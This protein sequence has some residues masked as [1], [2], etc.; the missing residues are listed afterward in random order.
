[1]TINNS[2]KHAVQVS[3]IR[4]ASGRHALHFL[5][6]FTASHTMDRPP[7]T[8][9]FRPPRLEKERITLPAP[10]PRKTARRRI[11]S[12]CCRQ[13]R[14]EWASTL[15]QQNETCTWRCTIRSSSPVCPSSTL[16]TASFA[17][18]MG[19]APLRNTRD[20]Y[21]GV[22]AR[23]RLLVAEHWHSPLECRV[24]VRQMRP[25]RLPNFSP[26]PASQLHQ[27]HTHDSRRSST[28]PAWEPAR[29]TRRRASS[30]PRW[31]RCSRGCKCCRV[32]P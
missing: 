15:L 22:R 5:P 14:Y 24:L 2:C 8:P 3:S 26:F 28:S 18:H 7:P 31:G 20:D 16:R 23:L 4:R 27:R 19:A 1:M 11:I 10:H 17:A 13:R 32:A 21:G 6:V 25:L 29:L 12:G 30:L 9:S